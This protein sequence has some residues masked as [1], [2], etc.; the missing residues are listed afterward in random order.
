MR[1]FSSM[2]YYAILGVT[3]AASKEEIKAKYRVLARK[4]HPD[5]GGDPERFAQIAE[6]WEVLSNDEERELYDAERSLQA[7]ASR[8]YVRQTSPAG[9]PADAA[10]P[11]NEDDGLS[12]TQ[13]WM[14]NKRRF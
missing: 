14:K 12:D 11:A 6:A 2:N 10:V 4:T 7:R 13:R 8:P 9:A 1:R 3:S 5:A